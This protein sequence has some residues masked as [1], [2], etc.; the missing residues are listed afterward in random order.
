MGS[1]SA[2]SLPHR[3]RGPPGRPAS[4]QHLRIIVQ[5]PLIG[6]AM[7]TGIPTAPLPGIRRG[8]QAYRRKLGT[9]TAGE[10]RREAQWWEDACAA[11]AIDNVVSTAAHVVHRD[12]KGGFQP[13]WLLPADWQRPRY[14]TSVWASWIKVVD[15]KPSSFLSS[16]DSVPRDAWPARCWGRVIFTW[17]R[18]RARYGRAPFE[19]GPAVREQ[20]MLLGVRFLYDCLIGS[21]GPFRG[22][23]R[24]VETPRSVWTALGRRLPR[25]LAAAG[26]RAD[27]LETIC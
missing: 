17:T 6:S 18:S 5:I 26:G 21:A 2:G 27:G 11:W 3:G 12:L 9:A 25:P 20:R 24:Y 14:P 4:C 7:G 10:A 1:R 23:V 13:I 16:T 15:R 19:A 22:S 8:G